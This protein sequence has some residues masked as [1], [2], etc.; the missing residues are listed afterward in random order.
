[1]VSR[2]CTTNVVLQT[3]R[4]RYLFSENTKKKKYIYKK[5]SAKINLFY[6]TLGRLD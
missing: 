2:H 3:T 6:Q 5:Y 4:P 1:M